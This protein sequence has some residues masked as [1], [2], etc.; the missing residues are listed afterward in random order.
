[1][2]SYTKINFEEAEEI[3][4]LYDISGIETL[5]P[6]GHGISNSNYRVET[7]NGNELILKISNDKSYQ[8]L[9]EE[10]KILQILS[11][12]GFPYSLCPYL[13]KAGE[14]VYQ[15]N[16]LRG[17]L[18]PFVKG[19]IPK[20]T[21]KNI[22]VQ[23]KALAELHNLNLENQFR[24]I[25]E[26]NY[27]PRN[28]QSFIDRDDCPETFKEYFN[29]LIE[30]EK[31]DF[32]I[33]DRLPHGLIH[34]DFYFD[35]CLF[36]KKDEL[37]AM[38]DFEQ[39]GWGEYVLDLGISISGS[40]LKGSKIDLKLLEA[41]KRGYFSVRS[42]SEEEMKLIDFSVILGL[43]SIALWRIYRFNINKID[44]SKIDNYIELLKIA[45][46]FKNERS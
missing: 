13:T 16:D 11:D 41:Y 4:N 40:C 2:A 42:M 30:P 36:N 33:K 22:E 18:Y 24:P 3:L 45:E 15:Y 8:K 44:A 39:A 20:P 46:Q 10:Q 5:M 37:A 38:L 9:L 26:L 28:I 31:F 35:N 14:P 29:K 7:K 19:S 17:V 25:A 21:E 6:M 23:A 12:K 1:M 43:F 34:G 32:F 27:S